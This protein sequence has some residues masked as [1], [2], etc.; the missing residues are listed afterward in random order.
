MIWR[1]KT[2]KDGIWKGAVV[3]TVF[4]QLCGCSSQSALSEFRVHRCGRTGGCRSETSW[5]RSTKS[6][7]SGWRTRRPGA[8]WLAPNSG[9]NTN[10]TKQSISCIKWIVCSIKNDSTEDPIRRWRSPSSGGGHPQAPAVDPTAPSAS[11]GAVQ[12]RQRPVG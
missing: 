4:V 3:Y 10:M 6:L 11:R 1:M 8:S 5:C 12:P 9:S 7:W 2:Q